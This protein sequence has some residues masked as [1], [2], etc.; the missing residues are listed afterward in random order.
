[1]R[2]I[3]DSYKSVK[4]PEV[5]LE[6]QIMNRMKT[7]DVDKKSLSLKTVLLTCLALISTSLV[8]FAISQIIHNADGSHTL[9]SESGDTGWTV[10]SEDTENQ[11]D[12]EEKRHFNLMIKEMV[13]IKVTGD[14][15]KVAYYD[16][17]EGRVPLS[18]VLA[19]NDTFI[20]NNDTKKAIIDMAVNPDYL[21][22]VIIKL[23][24]SFEIDRLK[25]SYEVNEATRD[26]LI[27]EAKEKASFGE[28]YVT[29]AAV[30]RQ[31]YNINL[32][33][34]SKDMDKYYNTSVSLSEAGMKYSPGTK[35]TDFEEISLD[36]KVAMLSKRENGSYVLTVEVEGIGLMIHCDPRGDINNLYDLCDSLIDTIEKSMDN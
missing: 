14:N 26:R 28:I 32:S 34:L 11:F 23:E 30:D 19:A 17:S 21:M 24:E 29:T 25:Y 15:A 16:Y 9:V 27:A 13:K 33:L 31:L 36:D 3:I 4:I 6:R 35:G 18:A 22:P 1:M 20:Y 2:K 7:S 12:Y 5:D 8:V 10:H